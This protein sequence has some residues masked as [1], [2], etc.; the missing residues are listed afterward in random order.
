M[1]CPDCQ[2]ENPAEA[3][4]CMKCGSALAAV[5]PDCGTELPAE[6]QFCFK[7][8]HQLA[9]S[10]V[11]PKAEPVKD[12]V[13][14]YIPK[15]MLAKLE[16]ARDG[17][18]MQ[19]ERRIVTV[20]FCDVKGSTA[21][22]EGLDPEEWAEI[23]DDAFDYLIAPIYRYEG[24]LAR[25][26]GDAILAFFGAPIA[27]EDDPQ[28]AILAGLDIVKDIAPFC[29]RISREHDLDFNVRVGINTGTVVVGEIGSDMAVEYTAM[30]DG[31]NLAARMEQTAEP[32]TVQISGDTHKLVAPLFDFESLGQIEIKGKGEPVA[33]YQVIGPKED[34]GRLRGI[35]GLDAPLI[36]R[37]GEFDKMKHAID[38]VRQGRGGIV[39]L[40]GE[41]GLGK[42]RLIE[43]SRAEWEKR[44]DSG[45][46]WFESRGISYD[47]TRPYGLFQSRVRQIL[48]VDEG[49]P[50]EVVRRK[51]AKSLEGLPPDRLAL[52][53]T[54]AEMVLGARA[55]SDESQLPAESLKQE[56]FEN[57]SNA[58]REMASHQPFVLVF[59][60]LHW[61][62]SSSMELLLHIF[63]LTEEVPILFLCAFRPDREVPGWQA[64]GAAET[65]YP[66]RYTEIALSPLSEEDS[67][68]LVDNLLTISDLPLQLR[69]LILQKSDGNPFFVEEV[70]RTLIDSEAVVR[71]QSGMHWQAATKVDDITIP[72]NLQALLVSRFDRLEEE[73]RR[74]LQ[75]ASVIGRSFYHRVLN[76]VSDTNNVLD[77]QLSTLQRVE[78]IR[79][80][81]RV[82]E[83]Q[84]MF[85]HELTRDAAYNSILH[86]SRRQFHH[87]VGEAIEELF[88]D[89]LEEE[90]HRLAHH[91][92]EAKEDERALKYYTMAGDAAARLYAN[93]EAADHYACALDVARRG[94]E[95]S[96]ILTRLYL[97]RGRA[98][99]LSRDYDK[100]VDN[101]DEM[102]T[103]AREG[104]DR[105]MELETLIAQAIF[106]SKFNP[107]H[108]PARCKDMAEE[109]L[110]L[111]RELGNREAEARALWILLMLN[112]RIGRNQEAVT[113]GEGS[114][115]IARELGLS[116]QL[117]YTLNDIYQPYLAV[118]QPE[119][120]RAALEEARH[121]WRELDN[122]PLL[123]N[124]L[125]NSGMFEYL[126]GNFEV[127]LGFLEESTAISKSINNPW[128][129]AFSVSI[130]AT[131]MVE[132]EDP[133]EVIRL[134]QEAIV[135]S[136]QA[137][138][139]PPQV[140]GRAGLGWTYAR[141]G[142]IKRGFELV[143]LAHEVA[144]ESF[145]VGQPYTLAVLARLHILSG[146]LDAAEAAIQESE[147]KSTEGEPVSFTMVLR[148]LA[149]IELALAREDYEGG[150]TIANELIDGLNQYGIR[151]NIP[152]ALLLKGKVLLAQGKVDQSHKVL[153]EARTRAEE[154]G[155][156][157]TLWPILLAL[158]RV[159]TERGNAAEAEALLGKA[160]EI[161]DYIADH[162]GTPE[163]R[164]SFL[165]IPDVKAVLDFD[166]SK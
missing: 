53:T 112:S 113:Y 50:P 32:G 2:A 73:V 36:G 10:R 49:D 85:R 44:G 116:E 125:T 34:P 155:S 92:Y 83:L 104:D 97:D 157:R 130:K 123:A 95:K 61:A 64:K 25:L 110:R 91:F 46:T 63:R 153:I 11:E 99:E 142:D 52:C 120:A 146:D 6:A 137:G 114:L 102:L 118:A 80:E 105:R 30:G 162:A 74:T 47:T 71:D 143:N 135:Y 149:Q 1:N 89:R 133:D 51:V 139:V 107:K 140:Y 101:Y 55:E 158:G 26:M 141:L 27:H 164:E 16:S 24:T 109:A 79:E 86:R 33:A 72:D 65:D 12:R 145:P 66:H 154:L 103:L 70:V 40:I 7:C 60:D 8:G 90:A 29:E 126:S 67:D 165:S 9:S 48:G 115:A 138:L 150:I 81:G 152:D 161:V 82:P 4:F 19:G 163:L 122:K 17:G 69:R 136:K 57:L 31:V 5:C 96:E 87:Q 22:A 98:L 45:A 117:A 39:C 21:M 15:E 76:F 59:D 166:A 56:L 84:Y 106:Y 111:G 131:L 3:K 127:A 18:G 37:G 58:W 62:D 119:K 132:Y 38:E 23:M 77:K 14:R 93:A 108:D 41:A 129:Q 160:K 100:V 134:T 78:L 128:G 75:L 43:E 124:V 42:S 147:K 159:E 54:A 13:K 20:L 28:R 144:K 121:L 148:P 151:V 156:R 88:S 35:E 94:E 68:V